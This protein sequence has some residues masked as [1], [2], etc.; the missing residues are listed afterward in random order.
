MQTYT[1]NLLYCS[2]ILASTEPLQHC[3]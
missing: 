2:Y 3:S 1:K